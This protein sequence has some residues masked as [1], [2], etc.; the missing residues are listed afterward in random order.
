MIALNR[1]R[2]TPLKT[3]HVHLN[4]ITV[5]LVSAPRFGRLDWANCAGWDCGHERDRAAAERLIIAL[6]PFAFLMSILVHGLS[7]L[8]WVELLARWRA[9]WVASV[10]GA[11]G[12]MGLLSCLCYNVSPA[13]A[14]LIAPALTL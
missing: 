9:A 7:T 4:F 3:R 13:S 8:A 12:G 10:L 5:P 11:V 1:P 2:H 6:L 14:T